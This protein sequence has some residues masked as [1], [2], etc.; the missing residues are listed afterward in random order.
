MMKIETDLHC[1]LLG[2]AG[3]AG[4]WWDEVLG[5][6]LLRGDDEGGL[7]AVVLVAD[8][9]DGDVLVAGEGEGRIGGP[10]PFQL[11]VLVLSEHPRFSGDHVFSGRVRF[12]DDTR[13]VV[14]S[15]DLDLV[16]G[17]AWKVVG[18]VLRKNDNEVQTGAV[19]WIGG[20][21]CRRKVGN[22]LIYRLLSSLEAS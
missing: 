3:D 16:L 11:Q 10:V 9:L 21:F 15:S 4:S 7:Q 8:G 12:E 6:Q 18:D 22:D 17:V 14:Q 2:G 5:A 20:R 19:L 1:D 13:A